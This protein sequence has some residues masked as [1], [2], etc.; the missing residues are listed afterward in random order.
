MTIPS[1]TANYPH[2]RPG[3]PTLLPIGQRTNASSQYTGRGV[4]MAFVD[5]GFYPHPDL[6]GRIR[7]Y[8]DASTQRVVELGTQVEVSD[9]SWHGQMTSVIACG[10]GSSS[11]GQFGGIACGAEMVLVRVSTPKGLVKEN[12]ILRGL[13]WISDTHRRFNIRVVNLSVGGDFPSFSPEHPLH[14]IVRKLVRAGVTVVAAAGNQPV[15]HLLPPASAADALT[16]GGIDDQ[17]TTDRNQWKL[18]HHNYGNG[19][20]G[21]PKPDLLAPAN[22][23]PSPIMPGTLVAR[24]A[25]LLAPLLNL[26]S[27]VYLERLLR[28]SRS[29]L[30]LPTNGKATADLYEMLQ[31][32]IHGHKLVD[33]H[34]QHVDGTSVAAP[35]VSAVIA[36]ML[37]ANP[38]LTP[39][40]IRAILT[41]TA[42]RL[43]GH[44]LEQQG[45]GILNAD[46]AIR[47]ALS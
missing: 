36:Q 41:R 7:M 19:F 27:P 45:A 34:H 16:V 4:V 25:R 30:G 17:N 47:A 9:L 13:R 1:F 23:V 10:D 18:Y 39:I 31:Q 15:R 46:Y 44:P 6:E 35:I 32:R 11:N 14:L 38:R 8:V 3:R 29:E 43:P 24:E 28:D 21:T 12:D 33:A 5:S 2:F 42:E 37:E 40:Q 26:T 22:W 20:D